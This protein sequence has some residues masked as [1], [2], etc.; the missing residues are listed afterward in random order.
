MILWRRVMSVMSRTKNNAVTNIAQLPFFFRHEMFK[1]GH[2]HVLQ[3]FLNHQIQV[4]ALHL[5]I[6]LPSRLASRRRREFLVSSLKFLPDI[7]I[8][9]QLNQATIPSSSWWIVATRRTVQAFS[10]SLI[11]HMFLS[12]FSYVLLHFSYIS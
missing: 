7:K 4:H 8:M 2:Q 9:K 12:Y 10:F 6:W 3:K 1:S 5:Q 11:S